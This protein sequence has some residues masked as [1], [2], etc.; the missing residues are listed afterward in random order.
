MVRYQVKCWLEINITVN[1]EF[2]LMEVYMDKANIMTE[3]YMIG[4]KMLYR[5][6]EPVWEAMS[7]INY[8]VVKGE[9][10]SQQIYGDPGMRRSGDVDILIDKDDLRKLEQLLCNEGFEQHVPSGSNEARKNRILCLAYSH[11]IPSYHKDKL[12]T[13]LN[14]DVN[15]DIFWGEYEGQRYPIKKFLDDVI[16]TEIY[17]SRVK[18]LTIEKAFV[19]MILHHYKEMNSLFI[20]YYRNCIRTKL[21]KDIYDMLRLNRE[22]LDVKCIERLC[23]EYEIG[24]YVY[25]LLFFANKVFPN[26]VLPGILAGLEMYRSEDVLN[27]YGLNSKERKKWK[28]PF[29]E[30]LDNN[31]LGEMIAGEMTG[32]DWKKIELNHHVFT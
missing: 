27:G 24:A 1:A 17:G 7:G 3:I 30:R 32:E 13:R 5:E 22:V 15:Y 29:E 25:Y 21:F 19:Q 23:E 12:W 26:E 11:Q 10:L 20:L 14:V 18:V 2:V 8:A 28:I 9:A 6:L 4:R 16:E 31:R